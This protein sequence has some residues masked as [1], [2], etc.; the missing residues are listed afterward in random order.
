MIGYTLNL[1]MAPQYM[2]ICGEVGHL[3]LIEIKKE[4]S[5]KISKI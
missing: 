5:W 2:P 1:Q 3:K 4:Q